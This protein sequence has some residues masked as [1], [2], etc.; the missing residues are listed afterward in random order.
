MPIHGRTA[1]GRRRVSL[2][3]LVCAL[4]LS[5]PATVVIAQ[6]QPQRRNLLEMLFGP[7]Q[8]VVE[9]SRPLQRQNRQPKVRKQTNNSVTSISTGGSAA[10]AATPPPAKVENAKTVLVVGDF[11]ASGLSDGL[12]TAFEASP[13]VRV[14]NRTNGSSGLVREDFYHWNQELPGIIAEIKP[15]LLVV[16]IGANDR[17]QMVT[18]EGRLEFRTDAWFAAYEKRVSALAGIARSANIPLVWVGLP[19]FRPQT[20]TADAIR[21][22]AVYRRGV[23]QAN[24]EFIDVW[25]GFVDQ[26]GRFIITGS[27][28]NGQQVRLRGTDG[29]GFT[30]AGK[31][32]LAFYAEKSV[33]RILGDVTSP[34][35]VRLDAS[36]LPELQSLP[37]S[38]M[39][40]V[41]STPPIS[42][43]DPELD[44]ASEL[45]GGAP[46]PKSTILSP[47]DLLVSN[48]TLPDPPAG[49]IDHVRL[50]PSTSTSTS[51][52]TP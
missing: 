41:V 25:D 49:R 4:L 13:G 44:G 27:D 8:Q 17:Q 14:E 46:L 38:E 37:P 11:V 16:Q 31:R 34:D 21:L 24:G 33:R 40:N 20:M 52:A 2:L 28:I 35:L 9:P 39:S 18:A 42:L 29:I 15:A 3:A 45:L 43:F 23:E 7:R 51:T 48:G 32:K 1:W 12:I 47:R 26:E 5:L 10:A 30:A 50:P 22:N 36:N 6:E 19:A